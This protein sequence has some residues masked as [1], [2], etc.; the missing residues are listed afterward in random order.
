[1]QKILGLA[2]RKQSGK[3]TS[4]SCIKLWE[5]NA[6]E[7]S[8]AD[9][10]KRMCIEI[11]GLTERQCY[12][13]DDD[14]NTPISHLLWENFP[15]AAWQRYNGA[16][17]LGEEESRDHSLFSVDCYVPPP[18]PKTGPMTARQV[19]QYWGSEIF[20]KAYGNVW[21]DACIRKIRA[22][23][24]ELAIITD[25]RFPNELDAIQ[26]AG[27]MVL[28]LTRVVFPEDT[29][30]SETAFDKPSFDQ[31]RFDG[32]LDNSKMST[33]EQCE[34]LHTLLTEWRYVNE[35]SRNYAHI[36]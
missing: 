25:C 31:T 8:F 12:G 7:F 5:P 9:P 23:D 36:F 13:S 28:Y 2:G 34:A 11:L 26:K 1:M 20:R 17:F 32:I 29:H 30:P 35:Y 18:I 10:L 22:S 16:I 4:Y 24:C 14:K 15:I 33:L 27:G 19:M 6:Q 3:S 21:A